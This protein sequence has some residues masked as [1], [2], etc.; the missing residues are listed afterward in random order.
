MLLIVGTSMQ[1][2]AITTRSG[3]NGAVDASLLFNC[4]FSAT[5]KYVH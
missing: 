3:D 5:M 1:Y 4:R 2:I